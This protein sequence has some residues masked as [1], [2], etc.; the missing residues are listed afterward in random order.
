VTWLS[1]AVLGSCAVL[2]GARV[3]S[4]GSGAAALEGLVLRIPVVGTLHRKA[5][6]ARMAR[7]LGTLLRSGIALTAAIDVV[8]DVVHS[9]AYRQSL[10]TLR[11]S[12]DEGSSIS[13]PLL[14]AGIYEPLF[15]QL[16]RVGEETGALDTMLLRL[17]D[18]YDL[19]VEA[20]LA[21]LGSLLEPA[22]IVLLGA[23]VGFIVAAIFIPLYTLIGNLK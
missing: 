8:M 4:S 20:A 15:V 12:L 22:M 14:Q 17:A 21:A 3:R 2:A 11:R 19:D 7:M 13:E 5:A 18:Y 9:A 1:A 16:A 6:A 10:D 23:A